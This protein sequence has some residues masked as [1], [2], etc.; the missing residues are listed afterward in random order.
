MTTKGE[1]YPLSAAVAAVTQV[2]REFGLSGREAEVLVAASEGKCTKQIAADL[3]VSRK[4]VEYFWTR[5]YAKLRCT[6]Q[7]EVMAVLLRRASV[8]ESSRDALE[9]HTPA[10]LPPPTRE[11]PRLF[12]TSRSRRVSANKD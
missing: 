6:S 12:S 9:V 2:V 3:G 11:L 5:I 4:T 7:V 8:R 1:A 10:L